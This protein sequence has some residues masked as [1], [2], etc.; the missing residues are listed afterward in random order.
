MRMSAGFD[1]SAVEVEHSFLWDRTE[2]EQGGRHGDEVSS[3]RPERSTVLHR[4]TAVTN[5]SVPRRR[6]R[7][8][9]GDTEKEPATEGSRRR[10][11]RVNGD[12]E[13]EPATE[14]SRRRPR[15]VNGAT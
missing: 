2:N 11:R 3:Y 1:V 14:G 9:D 6:P 7:R 4:R 12:T 10:P 5:C 15:R 8:V 13:E